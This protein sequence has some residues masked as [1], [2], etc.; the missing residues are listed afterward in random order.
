MALRRAVHG[1]F[2]AEAADDEA[3]APSAAEL[4]I[5]PFDEEGVEAGRVDDEVAG[6]R[7]AEQLPVVGAP[8]RQVG[9]AARGA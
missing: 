1:T 4:E 6:Q 8:L 7:P 9:R 3:V 2:G 5:G